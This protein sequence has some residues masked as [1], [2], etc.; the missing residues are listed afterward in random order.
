MPSTIKEECKTF[1]EQYEPII[2]ALIA[3]QISP[4]KICQFIGLCPQA[5]NNLKPVEIQKPVVS[6]F[7]SAAISTFLCLFT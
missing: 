7:Y 3:N 5:V 1:V 2:A 6:D 4:D